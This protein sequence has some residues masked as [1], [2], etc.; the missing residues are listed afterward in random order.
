M[1]GDAGRIV[2]GDEV[3]SISRPSAGQRAVPSNIFRLWAGLSQPVAP[4]STWN[5]EKED[6]GRAMRGVLVNGEEV[7]VVDQRTLVP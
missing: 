1:S 3:H 4:I 2:D 6:P 7:C 5:I